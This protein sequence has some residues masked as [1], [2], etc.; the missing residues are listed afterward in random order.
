M[1]TPRLPLVEPADVPAALHSQLAR[2]ESLSADTTF[3]RYV[4]HAPHVVD[5]YWRD[6][7]ERV[8]RDGVVPIRTKEVARL[9]LAA[10]SG[11]TFCRA[12]DVDSALRNGLTQEQV[13]GVLALDSSALSQ[14]DRIAFDLA[15]RLSPFSLDEQPMEEA[16]W[17]VLR[18]HFDDSQVAELLMCV[19][20]LAGVGRML[21][22]TGFVP[23]TC[24]L[25]A[26]GS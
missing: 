9:A 12:G 10:L 25:P 21:A 8:F 13:D 15:L 18:A 2:L 26:P 22:I 7:Y 23:R 14:G 19:S 11:C 6:F 17:Q 3:H 4:A 24:E 16:D 1:S 20:V 5:F